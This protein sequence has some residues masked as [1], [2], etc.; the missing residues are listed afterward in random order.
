MFFLF[1][2]ASLGSKLQ[3]HPT[4]ETKHATST[5][6]RQKFNSRDK[7]GRVHLAR[8]KKKKR[9]K[10]TIDDR[11]TGHERKLPVQPQFSKSPHNSTPSPHEEGKKVVVSGNL[12]A[13]SDTHCRGFRRE[14]T[15]LAVRRHR[16]RHR[17]FSLLLEVLSVWVLAP[18][19]CGLIDFDAGVTVL[20]HHA[21]VGGAF[22]AVFGELGLVY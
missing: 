8:G 19:D 11:N 9:K 7:G 5:S 10:T 13:R 15:H 18:A 21:A 20:E 22:F 4:S 3:A 14:T 17:V 12:T 2:Q 6:L 16:R 1:S